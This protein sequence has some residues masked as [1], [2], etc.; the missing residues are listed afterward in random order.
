LTK[1]EIVFEQKDWPTRGPL[2]F[3]SMRVTWWMLKT[4][5]KMQPSLLPF[6]VESRAEQIAA[7]ITTDRIMRADGLSFQA[8]LAGEAATA[9]RTIN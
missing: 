6:I 7:Q 2:D 1:L 3:L 5:N 8:F 9:P 4:L